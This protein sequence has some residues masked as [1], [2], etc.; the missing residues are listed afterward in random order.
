M[1]TVT[2]V[3]QPGIHKTR[4]A[5]P[6]AGTAHVYTVNK[7]LWPQE[8]EDFLSTRLVGKTLHVCC[9]KSMLGDVR[10]DLYEEADVMADAARLP[11][12]N[13]SFDTVLIDPPYN[14]KF[15]WMH[16]ML[17]E[18]HRVASQRIIHQHWYIPANK[19]GKFKKAHVFS[20]TEAVVVVEED[21]EKVFSN[22]ENYVWMPRT[23]FGRSQIISIFDI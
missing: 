1:A 23:Y 15:Q 5:V 14:G 17:N 6:L 16:D 12:A 8:V 9:G 22:T 11:F 3:N 7:V 20:L 13:D 21:S 2:Y 18:L 10:L 19:D 4:G